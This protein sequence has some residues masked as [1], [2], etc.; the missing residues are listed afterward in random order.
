MQIFPKILSRIAS[1][2]FLRL[3][4]LVHQELKEQVRS[5]IQLEEAI[6]KGKEE[7]CKDLFLNIGTEKD[8]SRKEILIGLKRKIF[9]GRKIS[10]N[11]FFELQSILEEEL[12]D[13]IK[14]L[15]KSKN[16]IKKTN[17]ALGN[18]IKKYLDKD[19][20]Y[21]KVIA[22]ETLFKNG[23]LLS[24]HSFLNQ[25]S[26]YRKKEIDS[27]RKKE[28][29][30]ELGLLKY[31]TRMYTKTSPF[32]SFTSVDIST[33]DFIPDSDTHLTIT[34]SFKSTISLDGFIVKSID[35]LLKRLE[36]I[37][38]W[39]PL[40]L[41][42]TL[43]LG[44]EEILFYKNEYLF[45]PTQ[46]NHE[47]FQRIKNTPILMAICSFFK[48]QRGL[49]FYQDVLNE[50]LLSVDAGKEEIKAYIN[51]LI[52]SGLLECAERV[53]AT[54]SNWSLYMENKME[55]LIVEKSPFVENILGILRQ[56]NKGKKQFCI[57]GFEE[58]RRIIPE[59]KRHL[60]EIYEV[61]IEQVKK[62][63]TV[64]LMSNEEVFDAVKKLKNYTDKRNVFYENINK[65]SHL[66][67]NKDLFES[68]F[69]KLSRLSH[70]VYNSRS[71]P[72]GLMKATSLFLAL[73]KTDAEPSL[74]EFHE[75]YYKCITQKNISKDA[76]MNLSSSKYTEELEKQ[77]R[78]FKE[79]RNHWLN[80]VEEK[81]TA[82]LSKG[83]TEVHLG[84]NFILDLEKVNRRDNRSSANAALKHGAY[85]QLVERKKEEDA[86]MVLN[87]IS[88]G[89]S[90]MF[91][92]FLSHSDEALIDTFKQWNTSNKEEGAT[93]VE[94]E[95]ESAFSANVHPLIL[96]QIIRLKGDTTN[97]GNGLSLGDLKI[98]Y[99]PKNKEIELFNPTNQQTYYCFDMAFQA[100]VL[101]SEM[102]KFLSLFDIALIPIIDD[103]LEKINKLCF[104][105]EKSINIQP[106]V[107]YA[108]NIILQR[109]TWLIDKAELPE[110]LEK[111]TLSEYFIRLNIW[112]ERHE[113]PDE[114]FISIPGKVELSNKDD[115]KPQYINFNSPLVVR[116]F[117]RTVKKLKTHLVLVEML[118]ASK[119]LLKSNEEPYVSE[120]LVQW[121]S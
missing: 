112:K 7:I 108:K 74:I 10:E 6:E 34:G 29:Q 47:S 71:N 75:Q 61:I 28:Y 100:L 104:V 97:T 110:R 50:L 59:I 88:S 99:H 44:E 120:F 68:L 80:A 101:R 16:Q 102:F 119:Q 43:L 60:H 81:L 96:P 87:S 37:Y 25:I 115:Y 38:T 79:S 12:Y 55:Q 91:S 35:T 4:P 9:N 95:D 70:V 77:K 116:L 69:S 32:G 82:Y 2:P 103:I 84:E 111:E 19:R 107:I 92:R 39:Y 83:Q 22:D 78:A 24:S 64:C 117:D 49:V 76:E 94:I 54:T 26:K 48:N 85:I 118:P 41:N 63:E 1:Q 53:T 5:L 3:A 89:Y 27:F 114:V 13:K 72:I 105:S 18:T 40:S 52:K 36:E 45:Y 33:P 30:T 57:A 86:I 65:T 42:N 121:Q 90:K 56:I 46:N 20:T 11:Q 51:D 73:Y 8:Q 31:L 66:K 98:R 14:Q 58:R 106:R 109:K 17:Q 15:L 23:L 93:F 62:E 113:I 67:I 21:L